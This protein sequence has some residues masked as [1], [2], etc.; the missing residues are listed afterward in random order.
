MSK[1]ILIVDDEASVI[2]LLS[3]TLEIFE[4]KDVE[5]LSALN[6]EDALEI[7][8]IEH[9]DLVF[10]DVNMPLMN[11]LEVCKFVKSKLELKNIYIVILTAEGHDFQ[12]LHGYEAGADFY[13]TKPFDPDEVIAKALEVLDLA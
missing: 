10:L 7:I 9:P 5:V 8:R 12:D 13:M 4:D 6:G 11:G 2:T 3:Q 1:K